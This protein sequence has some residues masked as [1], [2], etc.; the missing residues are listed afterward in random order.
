MIELQNIVYTDDF[1]IN[2][3]KIKI[4]LNLIIFKIWKSNKKLIIY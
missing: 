2:F 3:F 4:F 1:E